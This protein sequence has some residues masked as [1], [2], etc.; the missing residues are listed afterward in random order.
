MPD[1]RALDVATAPHLEA[2]LEQLEA[3]PRI[4]VEHCNRITSAA[5]PHWPRAKLE[6]NDAYRVIVEGKGWNFT[7]SWSTTFA[8]LPSSWCEDAREHI[9]AEIQIIT[10]GCTDLHRGAYYGSDLLPQK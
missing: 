5:A 8:D 2:L 6:E 3:W 7:E 9:A 1:R 10:H 4:V